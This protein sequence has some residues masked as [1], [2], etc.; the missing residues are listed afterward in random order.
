MTQVNLLPPELRAREATRRQ[1][2]IVIVVGTILLALIGVFYFLQVMN[3]SR[4]EDRLAAQQAANAQLQAQVNS[5]QQYAELQNELQARKTLVDTVF[6]NEV[7]WAGVLADVSV[8]IPSDA[9]LT[10]LNGALTP[11]TTTQ[12]GP[13]TLIGNM[14]FAG[15]SLQ[16]EPIASWLNKLDGVQGWVNSWMTSASEQTPFSKTYTFDSGVDLTTA[17]ATPRG[18]AGA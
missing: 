17:A 14:S 12:V 6:V 2:G 16:T 1:T 5:L 8:I 10:S 11:P 4:A 7:S 15:V 13:T 18:K 9:Y 3:E